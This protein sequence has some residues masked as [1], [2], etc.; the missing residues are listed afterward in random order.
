MSDIILE[1]R[2]YLLAAEGCDVQVTTIEITTATP[3]ANYAFDVDGNTVNL[4]SAVGPSG[5]EIAQ[6]LV[7]IA[8]TTGA[9]FSLV[10]AQAVG[11][12]SDQLTLTAR[13]ILPVTVD[14]PVGTLTITTTT[15][16]TFPLDPA[17]DLVS[18][19]SVEIEKTPTFEIPTQ[20]T[21][22]RK[23]VGVQEVSASIGVTC[24]SFLKEYTVPTSDPL[25]GAGAVPASHALL[26]PGGWLASWT[27]NGDPVNGP[28]DLNY[29]LAC[30]PCT[31][32]ELALERHAD[33]CDGQGHYVK[34]V[35]GGIGVTKIMGEQGAVKV[36]F[37]DGKASKYEHQYEAGTLPASIKYPD[38]ALI[39]FKDMTFTLRTISGKVY[40]GVVVSFEI[41][42]NHTIEEIPSGDGTDGVGRIWPTIGEPAQITL[43]LE[44]QFGDFNLETLRDN[45]ETLVFNAEKIGP[46]SP[47]NITDFGPDGIAF[48][49]RDLSPAP[50]GNAGLRTVVGDVMWPQAPG[51]AD[52]GITPA[53]EIVLRRRTL[54]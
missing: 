48:Q 17:T 12:G 30:Y 5:D 25:G 32:P 46:I 33:T 47:L 34:R 23:A 51:D 20:F 14:N 52:A 10:R 1:D 45:I 39:A 41:N 35:C 43:T 54:T 24:E 21:P 4:A 49:I 3:G 36:M 40:D 53:P 7:D 15:A 27:D 19:N 31:M 9:V 37:E 44:N 8:N 42:P 28:F 18:W 11:G 50:I 2:G 29:T 16:A 22:C 26:G 13:G 38:Q 6:E